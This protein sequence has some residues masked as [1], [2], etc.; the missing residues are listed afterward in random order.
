MPPRGSIGTPLG[1]FRKYRWTDVHTE[2]DGWM[3]MQREKERER[4][5][6]TH[7]QREKIF[8]SSS[9]LCHGA[10]ENSFGFIFIV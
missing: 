10:I 8:Y 7:R 6:H 5:T 9:D 2:R 4:H 1:Q 3:D